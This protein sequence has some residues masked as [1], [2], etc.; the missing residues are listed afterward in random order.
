MEDRHS[1]HF[2]G[3]WKAPDPT[4]SYLGIYDGHGGRDMVDFL[5]HA[6][7]FHVAQELQDDDTGS[8]M[9]D[10][11]NSSSSSKEIPSM[12]TRLERA[13]LMAD[14]HARQVGITSSGATVAVCLVKV[15]PC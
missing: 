6:M 14:L 15:R 4:M 9:K 13:F 7:P 10:D 11:N 2:A 8:G 1:I 12:E 5:E 3:S